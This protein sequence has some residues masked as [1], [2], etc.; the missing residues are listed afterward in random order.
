MRPGDFETI[1]PSQTVRPFVRRYLYANHRLPSPLIVHA[2]PTGY[3]Y[4]SNFFGQ[5]SGDYGE[6]DGVRFARDERWYLY[7][8]NFGQEVT[9]CHAQSLELLVC[10]LTPTAN[11]RLLG[12]PGAQIVGIAGPLSSLAP[13][14]QR[15]ARECFKLGMEA[16]RE[17]HL[18][19]ADAYFL[20]LAETAAP[21]D[22]IVEAAIKIFEA[23]NGAVR[24]AEVSRQL[25]ITPREINRRFA[26]IV[27]LRPKYFGQTLQINWVVGLLY[28]NDTETLTRIAHEARFY[29]QA[30]F[31]HALRRFLKQGPKEFLSSSH[32][33]LRD[34]LVEPRPHRQQTDTPAS[35]AVAQDRRNDPAAPGNC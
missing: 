3:T 21:E 10:E 27:G 20:R 17:E 18:A 16:S 31:N 8:Q 26:R 25:G 7:G 11:Y 9:F 15:I 24:V 5:S 6:I 34:F 12:I 13:P 19:E 23:A 22:P 35:A 2:K 30:H 1:A 29:D 33:L 4:F 14:Q 32:A 28:A